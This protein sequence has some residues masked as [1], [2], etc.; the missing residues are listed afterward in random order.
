MDT[1]TVGTYTITYTVT[2]SSGNEA[3]ATRTVTVSDTPPRLA[4]YAPSDDSEFGIGNYFKFGNIEAF[5]LN[6]EAKTL[7]VIF[8]GQDVLGEIEFGK[9]PTGPNSPMPNEPFF[10]NLY[11][12]SENGLLIQSYD[13][14]NNS[15]KSN[16]RRNLRAMIRIYCKDS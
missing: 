12:I 15:Q 2:D 13:F 9:Q 1:T 14:M 6:Y 16:F 4:Q 8:E 11:A 3:T 10:N 5:L 7:L